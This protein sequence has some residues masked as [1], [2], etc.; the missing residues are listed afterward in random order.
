M[1][2]FDAHGRWAA[3][4]PDRQACIEMLEAA[5]AGAALPY[6]FDDA[7]RLIEAVCPPPDG[8]RVAPAPTNIVVAILE[9]RPAPDVVAA[10]ARQGV[11]VPAM[12]AVTQRLVTHRDVPRADCERAAGVLT[13]LLS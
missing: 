7:L 12:D 9:G 11:L 3:E 2:H 13:T 10:A 4:T 5:A 6:P 1:P 8:L